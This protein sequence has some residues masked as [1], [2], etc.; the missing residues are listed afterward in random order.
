M[1]DSHLIATFRPAAAPE[2][3]VRWEKY[4]VSVL[5][6]R[7]FRIERSENEKFRDEATQSIWYRDMPPQVFS[8]RE[9]GD[10][11]EII[12][13]ACRLIL[14]KKREECL[15]ETDGK[16]RKIN[17]S[18]N[19]GG[20][21][22]TLDNCDGD[23]RLV[24]RDPEQWEK[25]TLGTG[26]CS[27][28]GVAVYDD[29]GSLT[30][31]EDGEIRAERGD[32]SD[33]YVFA[34]GRDYRAAVKAL[35]LLSGEVPMVPRFALGNWWSRYYEYTDR[36]YLALLEKFEEKDV[37]LTVATIDMDW[38]YSRLVDE[39]M[40]ITKK[41]RN[42]PFYGGNNGW[43]GYTWNKN[44]FPDY[45][46]FLGEVHEKNV[47][48]T[49]NLHP[50][51]GV[52]WWEDCY[53][54]MAEEMGRD[55]S[56]G[57]V[58][59]FDIADPK[60][61]CKYFS[62]LHKP[63]EADGVDFWWI[64]WQQGTSSGMQGLDP[65]WALNHYH[66]LDHA[67]N[68]RVPL[69]LSRYAGIGSH[70]YPLGFSG[71]TYITW[72]T[73]AYL[74]YF[75]ATA[76]NVG[77]TWWSHDIGGHFGGSTD[78]ELYLRHIQFGV[79]S[80]ITRLHSTKVETMTKEPWAYGNGTGEIA[81]QWLRLR[82]RMIP[83]LYSLDC[84]THRDGIALIE[85]LYYVWDCPEAYAMRKEYLF[86]GLLVAPVCTRLQADGY[87]RVRVWIPEGTWTDVFTG[88]VYTA[89]AG[90]MTRTLLRR[91]ESVPVLAPAGSILPLSLDG[92]NKTDNPAELR[93]CCYEGSGSFT[94]CEDGT[95]RGKD[96]AFFTDFRSENCAGEKEGVQTL[97]ISSQG[98]ASVLPEKRTLR[99][100]FENI[101]EGRLSLFADG[102]EM[103]C[104][105]RICECA[106][107]DIPFEAGR[108]YRLEV[109]YAL[110]SETEKL[111]ERAR[112]LL[113]SS[114]GKNAAKASAWQ[115]ISAAKT[116]EEYR[117]AAESAELS[118]G[119]KLRLTE[120]L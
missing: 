21:C 32:G 97:Y 39:E 78:G 38:H 74:P 112:N 20:T 72:N 30:L 79:F 57:E 76:S 110:R 6:D 114:E 68:H 81:A 106:A 42:T 4:R 13:P 23:M 60:F 120:T 44:L 47:K 82:H 48:I 46:R 35:Y 34:Y 102:K 100:R 53:E 51:L 50:A 62:V 96:G 95:E 11:C 105:E 41:G 52:R 58:I 64:D 15:I 37:P 113:R 55:S 119:V 90:G 27:R 49:L 70:R 29:S 67:K 43:T 80:P 99:I 98:D 3:I 77:Y 14:R 115:K 117:L 83:F 59:P 28:T 31:G 89:P 9:E 12:T 73:L 109:R 56:T 84:R 88:D 10:R 40:G 65:L 17:N 91:L 86:G 103:T 118:E 5:Q 107:A 54:K 1:L 66:T 2:N 69:I 36:S 33:E 71:D 75:T 19:L 108:E 45:R 92:G 26:V 16:L 22:R 8:V 7:L 104:K 94:L 111:I 63:Y 116:R 61:I 18:G 85:P 87:A 93:V 25:V 24:G 101:P